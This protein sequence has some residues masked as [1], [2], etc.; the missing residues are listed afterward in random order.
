MGWPSV[1]GPRIRAALVPISACGMHAVHR[2]ERQGLSLG[3]FM[4]RMHQVEPRGPF[5]PDWMHVMHAPSGADPRKVVQRA[6]TQHAWHSL[7]GL[8]R[9]HGRMTA[10]L[11]ARII[12]AVLLDAGGVIV[13][14]NWARVAALLA[15]RGVEVD[16]ARLIAAEPIAKHDL[17]VAHH[18]G[19]TSDAA[20]RGSYLASV[21]AAGRLEGDPDAIADASVQMEREHVARGIWEVMPEG[22]PEALARLRG[23]GLR[24]ALASNTE[25][26]FRTKLAE[27]GLADAFDHLGI[28]AEIGIEKPDERFFRSILDA[29]GV[30]AERAVHV[31]DLYEV[32][33]VGARAAGLAAVLVDPAGL[34]GDRDVP[35]VRSLADLPALLGVG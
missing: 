29:I 16:P 27:L 10:R 11:D 19:Q 6:A 8:G 3:R 20:R 17:D 24:V 18:I 12:D 23:A 28:S 22:T 14:P 13:D 21:M 31:G 32:D 35:R 5:P 1:A 2:I 4:R 9:H 34:Y 33:V 30:P 26:L 7:P 15:E 25:S